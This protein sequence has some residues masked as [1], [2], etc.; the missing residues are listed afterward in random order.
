MPYTNTIE[1]WDH[2]GNASKAARYLGLV[3]PAAFLDRRNPDPHIFAGSRDKPVPEC[4]IDEPEW[5]LPGIQIELDAQLDMPEPFVSGYDYKL[6]DQ[7]YHLELWIEK[8]TMND[9]LEPRCQRFG[10]DLVTGVGFQSITS[11]VTMLR[12]RAAVHGKPV[13]IFYISDFDPAGEHMPVAV[14]RQT[15]YWLRDY[16]PGIEIKLTSLAL[17]KEQVIRYRLPRIPIKASDLRKKGFEDRH[18]EGAV[19][20]DALEAMHPG[21]LARIITE[22]V[23]PYFDDQLA[24]RLAEADGEATDAA[25]AEWEALVEEEADLLE[26]LR[27]EAD[28]VVQKFKP[29]ATKLKEDFDAAMEPINQRLED[30]RHAVQAKAEQFQIDLPDR[31]EPAEADVDEF[32]WLFDSDRK[33]MEQIDCYR[34]YKGL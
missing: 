28:M 6:A 3:D 32:D 22:A 24:G 4:T 30:I 11:V 2:L 10:M 26:Q 25:N 8:S 18:G 20:L 1:C 13:R 34:A 23:R 7:R 27:S 29:R 17:T 15:E 12:Q 5:S 9:V 31:P 16:A 21:E 33:Y 19:E 14:A